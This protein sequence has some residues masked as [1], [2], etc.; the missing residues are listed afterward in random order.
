MPRNRIE[1][2]TQGSA[3]H[4]WMYSRGG[5]F[6]SIVAVLAAGVAVYANL[7]VGA[8][9]KT[10][11]LAIGGCIVSSIRHRRYQARAKWMRETPNWWERTD[12]APTLLTFP[13]SVRLLRR[14]IN[15][16]RDVRHN[17]E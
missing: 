13:R 6:L 3:D 15:R 2:E 1:R 5:I 16:N 4:A 9:L 7:E 11:A 8:S 12:E 10:A 17:Y 14:L